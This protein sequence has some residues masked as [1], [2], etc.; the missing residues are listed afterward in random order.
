MKIAFIVHDLAAKDGWSRYA[1]DIGS[2]LSECGHTVSVL[3]SNVVPGITWAQ[4]YE[5]LRP[6]LHSLNI[7]GV[8]LQW[9]KTW[10]TL[11]KLQA[12]I[13]H[14]IC[15]PYGILLSYIPGNWKMVMTLHGSYAVIPFSLGGFTRH[16]MM[17]CFSRSRRLIAVSSFTKNF[18]KEHEPLIFQKYH[19]EEKIHV[20]HNA[21]TLSSD[22][23]V[24]H[25]SPQESPKHIIGVGAVKNRKGYVHAI[26]ALAEFKRRTGI[27]FQYHLV[28]SL[29]DAEYVEKLRQEIHMC[30]L[31]KEVQIHGS[32]SE[33]ELHSLYAIADLFLLLSVAE[34]VYVEGFVLGFIEAAARG[35]PCI[36]PNTG[37]CPEAIADGDSGY[38]CDPYN[39]REVA[40]AMEKVLVLD[41]IDRKCCRA[42]AESHDI[43][44][45][46]VSIENIYKKILNCSCV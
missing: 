29:Q 12:D 32:I 14:V 41:T 11:R 36:G 22:I 2:A 9:W 27:P 6:P 10:W 40:E 31:E 28:G 34:G 16:A 33:Q 26:R 8:L 44:K 3:V 21:M 4:Q 20:V 46:V 35:I 43:R 30:H 23:Q 17:H 42:W 18:L 38:V 19:L 13:V 39:S 25:R 15:E 37:G 45:T 7:R 5:C 1:C 24:I